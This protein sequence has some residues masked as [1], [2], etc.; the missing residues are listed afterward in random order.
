MISQVIEPHHKGT[1]GG[2]SDSRVLAKVSL[3][4]EKVRIAAGRL[5]VAMAVGSIQRSYRQNDIAKQVLVVLTAG[6]NVICYNHNLKKLWEADLSVMPIACLKIFT[7][8][9]NL[10]R[11]L[12][13]CNVLPLQ[14]DFP[15]QARHKEVSI[16][17]TNYTLRHGDVGLVIVGGSVE[18]QTQ[19]SFVSF[20]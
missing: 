7:A 19:V 8:F 11:N 13:S 15:T 16:L 17:V 12:F 2:F 18:V 20:V 14:E 9:S 6:W 3:L 4:P 5:P 10:P 1:D